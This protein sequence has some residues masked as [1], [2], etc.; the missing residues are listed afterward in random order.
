[1]ISRPSIFC[2]ALVATAML[3]VVFAASVPTQAESKRRETRT[4]ILTHP[5]FD[6]TAERVGLFDGMDDGRI[7]TKFIPRDSTGGF[8]LVTNKSDQPLTVELPDAFVAVQVL[9]Q[10]GGGGF[11]GGFSGGGGATGSW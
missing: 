11:G 3:G 7:E 9:K 8:V 4:P 6:P 10:F 2:Q 5:K 1:M